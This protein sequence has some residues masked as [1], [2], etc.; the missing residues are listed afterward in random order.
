MIHTFKSSEAELKTRH[1]WIW[2]FEDKQR[3]F[4]SLLERVFL[5]RMPAMGAIYK[6]QVMKLNVLR[7]KVLIMTIAVSCPLEILALGLWF[8]LLLLYEDEKRKI[9]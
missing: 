4:D 6:L 5:F 3:N 2:M 8:L 9:W 1:L 7:N